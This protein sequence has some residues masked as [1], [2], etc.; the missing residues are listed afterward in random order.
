M[1]PLLNLFFKALFSQNCFLLNC[2]IFYFI[3]F[4][5]LYCVLIIL[6][7]LVCVTVSILFFDLVIFLVL[8]SL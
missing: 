7:L 2:S 5:C 4:I 8:M 6:T 3:C 1:F